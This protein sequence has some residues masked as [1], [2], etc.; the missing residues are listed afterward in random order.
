MDGLVF[1]IAVVSFIMA[2]VALNKTSK[3]ETAI[4]KLREEQAP[5]QAEPDEPASAPA[6]VWVSAGSISILCVNPA[7]LSDRRREWERPSA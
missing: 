4:F 1:L 6:I 2:L 7:N 5:S 3:L